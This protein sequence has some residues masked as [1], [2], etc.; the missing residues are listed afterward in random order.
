MGLGR[1]ALTELVKSYSIGTFSTSDA[2]EILQTKREIDAIPLAEE[3]LSRFA[4]MSN[5][6]G[7]SIET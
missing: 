1:M 5:R 3:N 7:L 4:R 6:L 2:L